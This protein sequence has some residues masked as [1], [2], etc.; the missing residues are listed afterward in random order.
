[1]YKET[2]MNGLLSVKLLN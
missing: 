2:V 1:V